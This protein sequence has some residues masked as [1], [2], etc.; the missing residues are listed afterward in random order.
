MN[1]PEPEELHDWR[2][3]G[4]TFRQRL[5]LKRLAARWLARLD[6]MPA[7]KRGYVLNAIAQR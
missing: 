3:A 2:F 1:F 6:A 4:N 5:G 7:R